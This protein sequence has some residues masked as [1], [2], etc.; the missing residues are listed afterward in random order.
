MYNKENLES[1]KNI[2]S[3]EFK[4]KK[5]NFL[6]ENLELNNIFDFR[7][8][9]VDEGGVLTIIGDF[10]L[11]YHHSV[12]II[13]KE[14][15]YISCP[16][17]ISDVSFRFATESEKEELRAKCDYDRSNLVICVIE[18]IHLRNVTKKHFIVAEE[19]EYRFGTVFHYKRENL[20]EGERIAEWVK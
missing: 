11:S 8:S 12:E 4:E 18:D 14:T 19:I 17:S 16:L 6:C 15:E 5:L 9:S 7:V 13:F 2:E 3:K 20:K 1:I 10:D